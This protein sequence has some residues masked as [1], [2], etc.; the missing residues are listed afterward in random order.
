MN[1]TDDA[2]DVWHL[3]KHHYPNTWQGFSDLLMKE[4]GLQTRAKC[5][6]A[7]FKLSQNGSVADF[8]SKFN[9]LA[10]RAG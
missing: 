4:F 8:K 10:R 7:L 9:K 1:L 2:A 3:F 5:Q 6:A